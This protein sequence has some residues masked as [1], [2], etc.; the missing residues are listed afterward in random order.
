[1]SLLRKNWTYLLLVPVLLVAGFMRLFD[2]NFDQGTFQ[3]PDERFVGSVAVDRVNIP[4]GTPL[5]VLL[6]PAHSPLNPR[7]NGQAYHYG[8]MPLYI[9]K[10]VA[11]TL[12]KV[13]N[14]PE[15]LAWDKLT[16]LGRSVSG[17]FDLITVLLVFLIGRRLYGR[18]AGLLAATFSALAVTQIQIAHFFIAEPY[19]V[20]FLTAALYFTVVLMQNRRA[21]A[22]AL[23]GLCLGFALACKVSVAPL[24][25]L[26]V[27]ALVLRVAYRTRT[28]MLGPPSHLDD[29]YG[30]EPATRAERLASGNGGAGRAFLL[31]VLAGVMTLI[32]FTLG[33]PFGV[34]DSGLHISLNASD[35]ITGNTFFQ[36]GPV[37]AWAEQGKYLFQ[38]GEE[39]AI[40]RGLADVPYTRQY[41]GTVPVLYEFQNLIQWGMGP[42]SGLVA[43][44][45]LFLAFFLALRRRPA[46][47]LLLSGMIPYFLTIVILEA[48][49]MRY[50]LPLV[51]YMCILAG[52]LL[53]RGLVWSA[54]AGQRLATWRAVR[55]RVPAGLL[56]RRWAFPVLTGVAVIGSALWATA[57]MNIYMHE[58]SRVIASRWMAHNLTPAA[59]LGHE[60]WDDSLPVGVPGEPNGGWQDLPMGLY[61]DRSSPEEFTYIEGLLNQ[62]DYIILASNRLY[63]SIPRLPWRYPVQIRYYDLLMSGKLGFDQVLPLQDQKVYPALTWLGITFNDDHADESFTV[64]DHPRVLVYKKVRSLSEDDLRTLF[65][66]SINQPSI[67]VRHLEHTDAKAYDKSLLLPE[68]PG[69]QLAL[70]DFAWNPLAQNQWVALGLWVLAIEV[71]GLLAW[72]LTA[73]ICRRLP[74]RGYPLSKTLGLV[75][76]AWMVWMAASLHWLPFTVWSIL[77]AIAILAG[78]AALVWRRFGG[79]LRAYMVAHRGLILG[80]EVLFLVAFA[81]FVGVRMLDPDLWQPWN[82]GEKPMEFGFLNA[83]LRSPWMPPGDPF[84]GGGTINYYYYGYFLLGT[85]I[86]LIGVP[87]AIG[88]NLA[89]P[90]LYGLTVLGATSIVYN[91]VAAMQRARGWQGTSATAFGWGLVGA[92]L[93]V[94]IGNLSFGLQFLSMKLPALQQ[95]VVSALNHFGG[96]ADISQHYTSF[97]WWGASRIIPD[98]INEFPYWSFL[99]ADL[100][101]HLIDLTVSLLALGLIFNLL[102]GAWRWPLFVALPARFTDAPVP[103]VPAP[104]TLAAPDRPFIRTAWEA[105]HRL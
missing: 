19:L 73:I 42:A 57:F 34:L 9:V 24:A 98:T 78:S 32:G 89:I 29:P 56:A 74:D 21:W 97:D 92:V 33:D 61:D 12:A 6:D 79:E 3:H 70:G 14:K 88:F 4:D 66:T 23:A 49:W 18:T 102:L 71:L 82:G 8:A 28:R 76:V 51:P 26:I 48:K 91:A 41:I 68:P 60:T 15:L 100:H 2:A 43:L 1:M 58:E 95:D 87:S 20:T 45:G 5:S 104:G 94:G 59:R 62:A 44:A 101:P 17:L 52:A 36:L 63:G 69:Q 16:V 85:V 72:P 103:A 46:E 81:L 11:A 25:L 35:T 31:L 53:A 80:W 105:G 40:Q 47:V 75:L 30:L 38:L 50:M 93:L 39:A 99:F 54:A 37:Q 67:A 7:I 22:A 10:A 84:F 13:Q 27:V 77:G 64:Y 90:L 65:G 55:R 83:V 86:K 96:V